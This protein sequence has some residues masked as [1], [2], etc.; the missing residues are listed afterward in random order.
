MPSLG[1]PEGV[2]VRSLPPHPDSRGILVEIYRESWDL[3]CR[4]VQLNVVSSA[5]GVLRGVHVH[6]RHADH[7]VVVAGRMVLGLHDLRPWSTTAGVSQ[8]LEITADSFHAVVIPPGVAHGF[9]FPVPSMH[10]YGVSHYWDLADE[11]SCRWDADELGLAWPTGSPILSER[12]AAAGGYK[13]F[14]D[15]FLDVWSR[16]HG[17]ASE[18]S[19][20]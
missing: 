11:M 12:D 17:T 9:Y 7:L 8:L 6:V 15:K 16:V 13:A 10:V 20:R 5:S 2:V 19:R 3:G 18:E 4:P 1:V 14:E